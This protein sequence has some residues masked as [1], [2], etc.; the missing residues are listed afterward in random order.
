MCAYVQC[1]A[2]INPKV[3]SLLSI[4]SFQFLWVFSY[5]FINNSKKIKITNPIFT[6]T[7]VTSLTQMLS[8]LSL[9]STRFSLGITVKS[10][11]CLSIVHGPVLFCGLSHLIW[12]TRVGKGLDGHWAQ[13][14]LAVF[15]VKSSGLRRETMLYIVLVFSFGVPCR[16]SKVLFAIYL[17]CQ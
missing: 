13:W 9:L 1:V 5:F 7:R 4:L 3:T 12:I 2:V 8:F 11:C 14:S 16:N 15:L 17:I 6:V 10:L